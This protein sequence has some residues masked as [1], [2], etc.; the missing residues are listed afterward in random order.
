M[1]SQEKVFGKMFMLL[2]V[3]CILICGILSSCTTPPIK[4]IP[5]VKDYSVTP[6]SENSSLEFI[7]FKM[8]TRNLIY[9]QLTI[10]KSIAATDGFKKL[11]YNL[12]QNNFGIDKS[13]EYFGLYETQDFQRYKNT[14]RFIT[15]VEVED[16]TISYKDNAVSRTVWRIA[17]G[18]TISVGLPLLISPAAALGAITS[19]LGVV[20]LVPGNTAKTTATFNGTHTIY[21]YDTQT[22]SVIRRETIPFKK[23]AQ[24]KGSYDANQES[25]DKVFEYYSKLIS[26]EIMQKY[27]EIARWLK[28][29]E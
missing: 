26:N 15:F 20:F 16:N 25:K 19:I 22:Q 10:A 5:E 27:E 28:T 23:E 29:V 17:S 1:K 13:N 14:E 8:D 12:E 3:C 18:L 2:F 6:Q 9:D 21:V 11:G 4:E 24:F 7:G